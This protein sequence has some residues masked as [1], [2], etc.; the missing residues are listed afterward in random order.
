MSGVAA[1]GVLTHIPGSRQ[2]VMLS[3]HL[4]LP[5]SAEIPYIA[6]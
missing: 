6:L 3:E 1:I 5:L 2:Q 4:F